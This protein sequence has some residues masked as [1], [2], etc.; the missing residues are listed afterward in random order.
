MEGPTGGPVGER[1]SI[2]A[3][4]GEQAGDIRLSLEP[5]TKCQSCGRRE[6]E[7]TLNIKKL[8]EH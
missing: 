5:V 7:L 3:S 1:P 2:V 4:D 6:H 8:Q